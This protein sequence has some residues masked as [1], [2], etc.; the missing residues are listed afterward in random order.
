[1]DERSQKLPL[2]ANDL[3]TP[4][5]L[6]WAKKIMK[7][8]M[9]FNVAKIF[10]KIPNATQ[11]SFYV[12]VPICL[13]DIEQKLNNNEYKTI[14]EWAYDVR[15]VFLNAIHIYNKQGP[16]YIAASFL[17]QWFN[18][19]ASKYPLSEEDYIKSYIQKLQKKAQK[20]SSDF[21]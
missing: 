2:T 16:N 9:S 7:E 4:Y 15:L 14:S 5:L 11:Y 21:H 18:K 8:L 13:S 10:L 12:K 1:M 17:N 19:H 3:F 6:T 20:L